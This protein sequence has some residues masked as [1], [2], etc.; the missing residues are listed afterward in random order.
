MLTSFSALNTSNHITDGKY[1]VNDPL[2][3]QNFNNFDTNEKL[4]LKSH[5]NNHNLRLSQ[6]STLVFQKIQINF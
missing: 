6:D 5:N 3:N 1:N 4:I 2:L